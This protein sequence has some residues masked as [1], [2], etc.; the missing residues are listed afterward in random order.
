M[1]CCLLWRLPPELLLLVTD[2]LSASSLRAL[3]QVCRLFQEL[4]GPFYL[5]LIGLDVT[6]DDRWVRL[7]D[8]NCSGLLVWR[9]LNTFTLPDV[10][11][12][13]ASSSTKDRPFRLMSIFFDS[14]GESRAIPSVCLCF[15]N[16]PSNATTALGSCLE[17]VLKSGCPRFTC[18]GLPTSEDVQVTSK[19]WPSASI[20]NQ[21][22]DL[23][24][25]S[26]L[27][28]KSASIV[29]TLSAL[30]K[31]HLTQ[32]S[33]TKI[34][35][36]PK[37]W[38]TLL[39]RT[40]LPLLASLEL[41]ED[42]PTSELVSFLARHPS[43]VRLTFSGYGSPR[44]WLGSPRRSKPSI[45][46]PRLTELSGSPACLLPLL[47]RISVSTH[48]QS[49]TLHFKKFN[50]G[51]SLFSDILSCS[52][53]IP[54]LPSLNVFLPKVDSENEEHFATCLVYPEFNVHTQL[55]TT[56]MLRLRCLSESHALVCLP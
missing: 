22:K 14:L 6:R 50:P 1:N 29:L 21:L 8:H 26:P 48:F 44:T 20:S 53:Y 28:F 27:M 39:H 11:W 34:A 40:T 49:L 35:F 42:C 9:R 25:S 3:T 7:N 43:I 5:K 12:Y 23:D 41:D 32:L 16:R 2:V 4:A 10:F 30:Q 31:T 54:S 36:S 33:I 17:S 19:G 47:R 13:S 18:Y 24:I 46:L 38:A 51:D 15:V 55:S 56:S 52:D 37:Q 45:V